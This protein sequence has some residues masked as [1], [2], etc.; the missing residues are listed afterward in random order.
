VVTFHGIVDDMRALM[1]SHDVIVLP[2]RS[3]RGPSDYFIAALEAMA[4]GRPVIASALPGMSE[5]IRHARDG[6]L[7]ELENADAVVPLLRQLLEAATIAE[8]GLSAAE[9][10]AEL[11]NAKDNSAGFGRHYG[12]Q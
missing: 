11:F 1:R 4:I 9:R 5:V 8:M 3:T 7:I 2:F 10:A 12:W 6:F